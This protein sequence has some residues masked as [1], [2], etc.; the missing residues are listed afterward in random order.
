MNIKDKYRNLT[1]H[2]VDVL[3]LH[4]CSSD[5]WSRVKVKDGFDP[6]SCVNVTFTG[7]VRLGV[8]KKPFI[9]DSGISYQ[10]GIFSARLHNCTVGSDVVI[11]NIGDIIA[12]YNIEDEAVI[13]NCGRINTDGISSFGNGTIVEVLSEI[14]GR[15]VKIW[16]HL[17]AHEAYIVALYRHKENATSQ[18]TI[19]FKSRI[20]NCTSIRNV[21]IGPFSRLDGALTINEGSINSCEE[22]PVYIGAGVILEHFIASS[23]SRVTESAQVEKCFIGQGCILAKQFTAQN[24]LFFANFEGSQSETCSVFAGPFTVTHHKSTLLIAGYFS[25]VNAGSGSNQSN[26]MYKLGPVHQ[27]IVERGSKTTS[28]SYML[29][30]THIGPFTM[31]KGSHY[32]NIDSSFLPFSYLIESEGE[33]I[34]LPGISLKSVG[35]IRDAQKWPLRDRRKDPQ[36]TDQLNF[37]MLTP[38]TVGKMIKGRDILQ[39]LKAEST[40]AMIFTY[41][42]MQIKRS[43]LERGIELYQIGVNKFLGSSLISRLEKSEFKSEDELRNILV[44]EGKTGSGDWVDLAGLITPKSEIEN[45]LGQIESGKFSSAMELNKAFKAMH[46]SYYKWEWTWACEKIEEVTGIECSKLTANHIINLLERWKI[47]VAELDNLIY[48]DARKEFAISSFT[49]FGID[50]ADDEKNLDFKNVRGE[51]QTNNL[52]SSITEHTKSRTAMGDKLINKLRRISK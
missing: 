47:S 31:V 1:S 24:S 50:G 49:G 8:F 18:G 46:N 42:N 44:P 10:S 9:D 12:N 36:K 3:K 5:D 52:V 32:K 30:P 21:K 38:F 33:S 26:H 20:F 4:G 16:D 51:F 41:N 43:S 17:S 37:N 29:W 14:G 45:L 39:R 2:E 40:S 25:F 28:N 19:G 6:L 27:G 35:T 7:Y 34:L 22:D 13:K 23:G 15:A 11:T 48:E